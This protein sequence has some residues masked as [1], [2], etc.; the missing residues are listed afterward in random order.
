[1]RIVQRVCHF[2]GKP[3][4]FVHA[5]LLFAIE[6]FPERFTLEVFHRKV[7]Y[8]ANLPDVVNGMHLQ[9]EALRR[10]NGQNLLDVFT[11]SYLQTKY[12]NFHWP[13]MSASVNATTD[14]CTTSAGLSNV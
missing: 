3:H 13:T 4:G 12:A 6:L 14:F 11:Q 7:R 10:M 2:G 1:M 5:E 8:V 9:Y